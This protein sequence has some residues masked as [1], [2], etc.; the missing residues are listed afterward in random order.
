[1]AATSREGGPTTV[2]ERPA[3]LADHRSQPLAAPEPSGHVR[4]RL[5]VHHGELTSALSALAL[6]GL[7]FLTK[8]YGVAGVPDPSAARPAISTAVNGY[9]GLTLVRWVLLATISA[10]LG[11]VVLHASQRKHGTKTDTSRVLTVLGSL[12]A[13]LLIYRV[14]IALPSASRVTDQK[15]GA[16]LGLLCA[17]GIALGGW[18][19]MLERK[20]RRQ[21][22]SRQ[23]V[24]RPEVA[25]RPSER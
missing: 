16:F 15:L 5:R 23:S 2:S 20:A 11:S 4:T 18:Q 14:L 6:L 13:I 22:G 7:M 17:L 12:S 21:A 9:N 24:G 10:A 19:S 25:S 3:R 1:M 8:W